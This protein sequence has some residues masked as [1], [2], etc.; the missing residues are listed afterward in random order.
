MKK[1]V[2]PSILLAIV[3]ALY[4]S[5]V[6]YETADMVVTNAMVMTVNDVNPTAE[7]FAIK[8][9]KF[10]AVGSNSEIKNYIGKNT[11]VINAQGK[12]ITPGFIDAH[13]HANAIYPEDHRLGFIDLT[14]PRV[15]SMDDLIAILKKKAAIT[16][17]G[18]WII[19]SRY[20]DTKLGRHPTRYDLDKVSTEHPIMIRHSSGHVGVVNSY[21]LD[22]A[23]IDQN[24][25]DP[26]GGA[27][28]R[29]VNGIPNGM[30]R[31]TAEEIV[32][33]AGPKRLKANEKE[34]LD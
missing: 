18:E 3:F 21:A 30:C 13:V 10:I 22:M 5:A 20:Y 12:T 19:G 26:A 23:K 25:P 2:I 34:E 11:E 15:S 14:P 4:I 24:T 28:D 1:I 6:R 7:A 9:G 32:S 17:K 27:F 29:D 31:E 16:P 8:D 33:K